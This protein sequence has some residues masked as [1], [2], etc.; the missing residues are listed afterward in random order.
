MH[1]L[2]LFAHP[3]STS[4]T[5]STARQIAEGIVEAGGTAEVA[6]LASEGFD[7]RFSDADLQLMQGAGPVPDDVRREQER[8][9]RADSIVL[10][11]PVYWWSMPS[12]LKGWIDRVLTFGLG[13][14]RR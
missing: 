5:A 11:H 12:L 13:L 3:D 14:R 9:E 2:V 1:T 7:P 8:V 10:A 4:L 6:D